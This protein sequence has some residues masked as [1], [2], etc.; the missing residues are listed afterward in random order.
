MRCGTARKRLSDELGGALSSER[1][2]RLEAHLQRC[3]ACR[4][5]REDLVRLQAEVLPPAGRS[6]EYWA[7][8][9]ERLGSKLSGLETGRG[10]VEAPFSAR[11]RWAWAAAGATALAVAGIGL[12]ILRP[13]AAVTAAWVPYEDGLT[14]LI[15]E[16]EAD[17]ELERDLDREILASIE[18]MTPVPDADVAALPAADPLFWEGLSEDEL[19]AIASELEKETGPGGPK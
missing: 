7:G 9:D 4:G 2:A 8:F 10:A 17:P 3:P 6:P 12:A 11:R 5:Y 1:K 18:E 16:A 14:P 13:R 19:R 15:Q